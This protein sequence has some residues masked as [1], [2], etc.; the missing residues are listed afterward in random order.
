M[1][2]IKYRELAEADL[3]AIFEAVVIDYPTQ[4]F[5]YIDKLQQ[6]I[7]LLSTNPYLGVE[8]HT[9]N[10]DNN[11]RVLIFQNYLIIYE[12]T[13]DSIIVARILNTRFDYQN[14]DFEM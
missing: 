3:D 11:C 10:I 2:K 12:V 6:T 14:S 7:Q 9:K 5:E 1:L 4:A 8:C 13:A